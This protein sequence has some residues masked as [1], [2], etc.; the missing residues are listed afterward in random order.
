MY[1]TAQL[2]FDNLSKEASKLFLIPSKAEESSTDEIPYSRCG[3]KQKISV[4]S[5]KRV[6]QRSTIQPSYHTR[7]KITFR[8]V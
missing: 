2:M 3:C 4:I 7:C 1:K 8:F 5:W 6:S